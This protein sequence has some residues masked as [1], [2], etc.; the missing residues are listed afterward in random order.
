MVN[1]AFTAVP[2]GAFSHL[3]LLQFLWV[4]APRAPAAGRTMTAFSAPMNARWERGRGCAP[5]HKE[6]LVCS[7]A[8]VNANPRRIWIRLVCCECFCD[9]VSRR[10]L[11]KAK[12]WVDV[13]VQHLWSVLPSSRR[14]LN[15]N[16]F[17]TIADDAFAGLSHLQ[18]LWVFQCSVLIITYWGTDGNN[19]TTL[20][21]YRVTFET[22]SQAESRLTLTP[23]RHY[24]SVHPKMRV[25]SCVLTPPIISGA[26]QRCSFLPNNRNRPKMGPCSSKLLL[27]IIITVS[28][29]QTPQYWK[30]NIIISIRL[31]GLCVFTHDHMT[32][33]I[34]LQP[35]LTPG[36]AILGVQSRCDR[37]SKTADLMDFPSNI[38]C[39]RYMTASEIQ[40]VSTYN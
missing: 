35:C 24:G 3:H 16:T 27:H 7:D 19:K 13:I 29:R 22:N 10:T 21:W 14:L 4:L 18:Y 28:S 6:P 39:D 25:R 36:T 9:F 1:A 34:S 30:L 8:A 33:A 20:Q 15:S 38:V 12:K 26:K 40:V 17:T 37:G 11:F 32:C 23:A 5:P 2:E 31:S